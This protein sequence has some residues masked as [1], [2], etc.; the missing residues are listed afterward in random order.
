MSKHTDTVFKIMILNNF[1]DLNEIRKII[2][3]NRN[4]SNIETNS[5]PI[6][7]TMYA[8]DLQ[9]LSESK[10]AKRITLLDVQYCRF[11]EIVMKHSFMGFAQKSE[12]HKGI[13]DQCNDHLTNYNCLLKLI[14]L[15]SLNVS[16][17][18]FFKLM[19]IDSLNVLTKL[20]TLIIRNWI[21]LTKT[22]LKQLEQLTHIKKIELTRN[23]FYQDSYRYAPIAH[24]DKVKHLS[25]LTNL[26]TLNLAN[27][28]ITN[29]ALQCMT[30]MQGLKE[31][32]LSSCDSITLLTEG[33]LWSTDDGLQYVSLLTNLQ[34]L[35]LFGCSEVTNIGIKYLLGLTNLQKLNISHCDNKTINKTIALLPNFLN[36]QNLTVKIPISKSGLFEVLTNINSLQKLRVS[37]I[38]EKDDHLKIKKECYGIKYPCGPFLNNIDCSYTT[39]STINYSVAN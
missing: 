36:L 18:C 1:L 8:H 10:Y 28:K 12:I 9:W 17:N 26:H 38:H 16:F 24:D 2:T 34:I 37:C 22:K 7:A 13:C 33:Y 11:K 4:C 6:I 31:L 30:A 21:W 32:D 20:Q 5:S 39:H 23:T 14:N 19:N 15:K 25:L 3:L 29:N 27:T 35:N